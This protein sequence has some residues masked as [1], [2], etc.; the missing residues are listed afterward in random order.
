ME[1]GTLLYDP[2]TDKVGEFQARSGKYAML[3][4]VGGGIEWQADPDSLRPPTD[5]ERIGAGV[6]AANVQAARKYPLLEPTVD[7]TKV[8]DPHPNCARCAELVRLA[9]TA[10]DEKDLS[11]GVDARVLMRR[12]HR[13]AHPA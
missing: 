12:H 7:I 10:S 13:Q 11:A 5:S 9:Q 3:R 6:K 4:P 8:P 1:P 2:T